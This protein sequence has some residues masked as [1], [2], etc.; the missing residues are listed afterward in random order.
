VGHEG[1]RLVVQN[2]GNAV[3]YDASNKPIWATGT[4]Q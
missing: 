1:S 4:R 3:I 2:D